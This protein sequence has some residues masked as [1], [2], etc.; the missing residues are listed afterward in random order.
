MNDILAWPAAFF[1]GTSCLNPLT[2][3]AS[4]RCFPFLVVAGETLVLPTHK[5]T[6]FFL[7]P[8]NLS[9]YVSIEH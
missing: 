2:F 6:A 4:G 3:G 9:S 1:T 8:L 7:L 5:L